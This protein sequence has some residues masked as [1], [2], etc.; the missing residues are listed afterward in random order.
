MIRN[1]RTVN[2]YIDAIAPLHISRESSA[3]ADPHRD[4]H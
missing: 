2:L 4:P 3:H 1:D